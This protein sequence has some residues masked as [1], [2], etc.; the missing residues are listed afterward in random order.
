MFS[1]FTARVVS[2]PGHLHKSTFPFQGWILDC[3]YLWKP[4]FIIMRSS[5]TWSLRQANQFLLSTK[6]LRWGPSLG[7]E[8]LNSKQYSLQ[9]EGIQGRKVKCNIFYL[10]LLTGLGVLIILLSTMVTS[11][12]GLS[13]SAIATNGFVHGGKISKIYKC[14]HHLLRVGKN[15]LYIS[16][17]WE[18]ESGPYSWSLAKYL[19]ELDAEGN[20]RYC[21]YCLCLLWSA[22]GSSLM[23]LSGT[24]QA[25]VSR[26]SDSLGKCFIFQQCTPLACIS[27]KMTLWHSFSFKV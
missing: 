7:R 6:E 16:F 21:V 15:F 2:L 24:L 5:P 26:Y 12:T 22:V 14:S 17:W 10:S 1:L 23:V 9:Q 8:S 19:D 4:S 25:M 11:I 20:I 13:T 27:W 3:V 18:Q